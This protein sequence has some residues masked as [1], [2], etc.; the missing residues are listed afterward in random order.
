MEIAA[1][2]FE[3]I[4]SIT[5]AFRPKVVEYTITRSKSSPCQFAFFAA[6]NFPPP[7]PSLTHDYSGNYDRADFWTASSS[8]EHVNSHHSAAVRNWV[9]IPNGDR[10][11]I[12]SVASK[13]Y[14][15]RVL[16]LT[17]T[18]EEIQN[19]AHSQTRNVE[20]EV[21]GG[22]SGSCTVEILHE[23]CICRK[24]LSRSFDYRD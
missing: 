21:W 17:L 12:I 6:F 13:T 24:V 3:G 22:A 5:P 19:C 14:R 16:N 15:F 4:E 20:G 18:E 8:V 9:V 7:Y 1:L 2:E 10:E 23:C 11:F